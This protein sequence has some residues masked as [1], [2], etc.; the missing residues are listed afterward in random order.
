MMSSIYASA[1]FTIFA[2]DGKDS[3]YGLKGLFNMSENR[4]YVNSNRLL[5]LPGDIQILTKPI[6]EIGIK[7]WH[8]RAWTFQER[9]I[10][11][12]SLLFYE[13]IV[14]WD[15][16]K[17]ICSEEVVEPE[18]AGRMVVGTRANFLDIKPWP[19]LEL[20]WEYVRTYTQRH[21]TYESDAQKAFNAII[22]MMSRS[23]PGGFYWGV[24][25]FYFDFMLLVS[26]VEP[27]E[28]REEFPTWSWLG[29]KSKAI[30]NHF[31]D[32][33][34]HSISA[35]TFI[36]P[37]DEVIPMVRWSVRRLNGETVEIGNQFQA[38][39]AME[40]DAERG[41]PLPAGWSCQLAS[42]S[43]M[44]KSI[45]Y[46]DRLGERGFWQPLPVADFP[47]EQPSED[48]SPFLTGSTTTCE[49]YLGRSLKVSPLESQCLWVEILD[50]TNEWAGILESNTAKRTDA[51][52]LQGC[53][54]Q[55][56]VI[57]A[58]SSCRLWPSQG[59]YFS[60]PFREME[61]CGA[62]KSVN[63]YEFYNVFWIE[64]VGGIAYKKA[65]GRVWKEVWDRQGAESVD[66][67]L[68]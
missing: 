42:N 1:Y 16:Q 67:V 2:L 54:C 66:L 51:L 52:A 6:S 55:L 10:S 27:I 50:S 33:R 13:G 49:F 14:I 61:L 23:F 29:W 8:S 39:Q 41:L 58:G 22:A 12:R 59:N 64:L 57:S 53:K 37:Q 65:T 38:Y 15:C 3:N 63:P 62:L 18:E 45:F 17:G 60:T 7:E 26:H 21:L 28:R 34:F 48:L 68:G 5:K 44:K 4:M 47:L 43:T 32:M 24:P 36:Y 56:A 40:K 11:R 25:A 35:S 20:Y 46:H 9:V 19:D 31:I 30:R